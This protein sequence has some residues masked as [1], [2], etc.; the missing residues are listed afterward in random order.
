MEDKYFTS[1]GWPY[2]RTYTVGK[3]DSSC[4][5]CSIVASSNEPTK[6]L[7]H[8]FQSYVTNVPVLDEEKMD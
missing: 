7:R 2:R 4:Y 1:D 6:C 5:A 3:G 8:G